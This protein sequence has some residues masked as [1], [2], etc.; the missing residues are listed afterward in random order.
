MNET[1]IGDYKIVKIRV[2]S[3]AGYSYT[4]KRYVTKVYRRIEVRL[5]GNYV[6]SW[7]R[8]RDAERWCKRQMKRK[9]ENGEVKI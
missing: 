6:F 5:N 7:R 1:T 3:K 4:L 2:E 8:Y 9:N